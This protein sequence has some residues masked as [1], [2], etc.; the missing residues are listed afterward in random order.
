VRAFL[1]ENDLEW[2]VRA[3]L[4]TGHDDIPI[5]PANAKSDED[6]S[7]KLTVIRLRQ[8]AG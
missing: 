4:N 2:E 1:K 5:E 7:P 8:A 6:A 3:Q